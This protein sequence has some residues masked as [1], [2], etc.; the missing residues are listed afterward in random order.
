[1]PGMD[2]VGSAL[3]IM[4]GFLAVSISVVTLFMWLLY[5]FFKNKDEKETS[6]K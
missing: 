2:E 3:L 4:L 5:K 1:M 6:S